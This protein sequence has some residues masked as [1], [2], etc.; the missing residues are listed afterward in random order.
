[1]CELMFPKPEKKK[2]GDTPSKTNPANKTGYLLH[3]RKR[4]KEL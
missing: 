2:E 3:V 4:G 1:M